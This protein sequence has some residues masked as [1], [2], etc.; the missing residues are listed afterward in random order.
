MA[1]KKTTP[2][3]STKKPTKKAA[4]PTSPNKALDEFVA[5]GK[6]DKKP[7]GLVQRADGSAMRRLTTYVT[8]ETYKRVKIHVA[9]L[10]L[11]LTEWVGA[12]IERELG[13]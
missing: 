11:N 10:D 6:G 7:H 8:P 12:L 1:R 3:Y 4:K 2:K 13:G 9:G 5:G